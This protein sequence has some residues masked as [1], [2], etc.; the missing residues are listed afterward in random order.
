MTVSASQR[1]C[2]AIDRLQSKLQR[3][4]KKFICEANRCCEIKSTDGVFMKQARQMECFFRMSIWTR[5]RTQKGKGVAGSA[6]SLF[7]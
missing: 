5:A 1:P 6:A 7:G 3:V 2:I 4:V